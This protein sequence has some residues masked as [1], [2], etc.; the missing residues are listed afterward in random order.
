MSRLFAVALLSITLLAAPASAQ[1]VNPVGNYAVQGLDPDKTAYAG[2]VTVS[3][4]GGAGFQVLW[5][6][7][8]QKVYGA[9]MLVGNA[10]YIGSVWD[11]R[12]VVSLVTFAADGN[13]EGPWFMREQSQP[14]TERWIK[15]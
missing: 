9:A 14:G 6:V 3:P 5:D 11:K 1:T 4:N 7:D 2:E 8:G 12:S 13:A 10:L 15:K